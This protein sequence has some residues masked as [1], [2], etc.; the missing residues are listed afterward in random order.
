VAAG[1]ADVVWVDDGYPARGLLIRNE[2]PLETLV[3]GHR[4]TRLLGPWLFEPDP[5]ERQK[6]ALSLAQKTLNAASGPEFLAIKAAQDPAVIRGFGQAGF[7]VAE[8][9][10][11]LSGPIL[12]ELIPEFPVKRREGL[13][14]KTPKFREG[15]EWLARLGDLFYDGHYLNGPYLPRDFSGKLWR[16]V[17]QGLL[18]QGQP[19][20]F[21]W[22]ELGQRPVAMALASVA[23]EE[24]RLVAIHVAADRRGQGLGEVLLLEMA[25][26]L[27]RRGAKTLTAETSSYN[28]PA[29]AL[30]GA[31]GLKTR[32]P[33]VTLHAR[34][35]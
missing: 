34:K 14:L 15:E 25:R 12:V 10:S 23:G 7:E 22:E 2:Q 26:E 18:S 27:A 29:L 1:L 20:L 32:A 35:L 33:F 28:L 13:T 16:A 9:G 3:L 19:A 6:I 24:A 17:C 31:I 8:I 4:A 11:E 5:L 30:Y 21:L